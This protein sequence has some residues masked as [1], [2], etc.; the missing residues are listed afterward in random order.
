MDKIIFKDCP[1]CGKDPEVL[2]Q[3][4]GED[5]YYICSCV[6]ETCEGWNRETFDDAEACADW[7]NGRYPNEADT[8]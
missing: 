4:A 1:F 2:Q 6:D 7:W 5:H 8:E 3:T